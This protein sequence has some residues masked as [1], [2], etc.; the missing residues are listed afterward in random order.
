L[1]IVIAGA[2]GAAHLPGMIAAFAPGL[3][4]VGVPLNR[5]SLSGQDALMSIVRWQ[6]L[7]KQ[8]RTI[9]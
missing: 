1:Q 7:Q 2:G 6:K 9:S 8:T 4:V 3:P 5:N